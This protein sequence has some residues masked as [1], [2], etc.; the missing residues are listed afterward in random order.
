MFATAGF[1]TWQQL[2]YIPGAF[3]LILGVVV[4]V[5]YTDDPAMNWFVSQEEKELLRKRRIKMG[6][7]QSKFEG[8][9][10]RKWPRKNH[11]LLKTLTSLPVWSI[12]LGTFGEAWVFEGSLTY[13]QFFLTGMMGYSN[14]KASLL[15]S[16]PT[17]VSMIVFCILLSAVSEKMIHNG[18]WTKR[19]VRSVG[20]FLI[21]LSPAY[22]LFL[23]FLPCNL[24]SEYIVLLLVLTSFRA[25][26]FISVQPNIID[27]SPTFQDAILTWSM[28]VGYIPTF[29]VPE[30]MVVLGTST[31]KQWGHLFFLSVAVVVVSMTLCL[32]LMRTERQDFDPNGAISKVPRHLK[33]NE[34]LGAEDPQLE[35]RLWSKDSLNRDNLAGNCLEG[36]SDQK[37]DEFFKLVQDEDYDICNLEKKSRNVPFMKAGK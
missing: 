13:T 28:I 26:L 14:A 5:F 36:I 17:N 8:S 10:L 18:R 19:T 6:F 32:L 27:V 21:V 30:L 33:V 2:F 11:P 22:F 23:A 31:R 35:V 34:S 20:V 1:F 7:K 16:L 4:L 3:A 9:F 12:Y 25:G 37:L 24:I 29:V 15:N